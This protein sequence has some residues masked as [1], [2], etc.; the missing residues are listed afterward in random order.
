MQIYIRW[1]C[2]NKYFLPVNKEYE[3]L[4]GIGTTCRK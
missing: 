1:I 4:T 3:K 2:Y